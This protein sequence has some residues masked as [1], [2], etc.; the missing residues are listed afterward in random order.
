MRRETL[1]GNVRNRLKVKFP[2]RIGNLGFIE[3]LH[4][5]FLTVVSL[6]DARLSRNME[7]TIQISASVCLQELHNF[8]LPDVC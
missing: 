2:V 4:Q 3:F 6:P 5:R 8:S 1:G 7:N